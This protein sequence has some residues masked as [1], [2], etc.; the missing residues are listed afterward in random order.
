MAYAQKP[1]F[2]FRLNGRVHLIRQ[3]RQFSRILA[4]EVC[5]SAVVLLDTPCSE[6][7]WRVLATHSI[8][9]VSPSLPLPCVTV[10]YHISTRVYFLTD[11]KRTSPFKSAGA[12]VQSTTG[13]AEVCGISGSNAGYTMFRGSV[14]STG[15][16]IHSPVCLTLPHPCVECHHISTGVYQPRLYIGGCWTRSALEGVKWLASRSDRFTPRGK[17]TCRPLLG[18]MRG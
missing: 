8:R 18:P 2:V 3:G 13:T 15:Y 4:A 6:V 7:V 12:S 16:P 9:L 5:A 17:N 14:K 11:Y 10:C 1:D